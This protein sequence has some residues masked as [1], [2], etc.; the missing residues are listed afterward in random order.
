VRENTYTKAIVHRKVVRGRPCRRISEGQERLV[1]EERSVSFF[2]R[3][4]QYKD[5][6]CSELQEGKRKLALIAWSEWKKTCR[7]VVLEFRD[8]SQKEIC[9]L[10]KKHSNC[11]GTVKLQNES[12]F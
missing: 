5:G 7:Y 6:V 11:K 2:G 1:R 12:K 4:V 3:P 9:R 10:Q 8:V